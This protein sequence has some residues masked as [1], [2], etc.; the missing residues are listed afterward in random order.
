MSGLEAIKQGAIGAWKYKL[1]IGFTLLAIGL[2]GSSVANYYLGFF[3][4]GTGVPILIAF[5]LSGG[6]SSAAA[7]GFLL[8]QLHKSKDRTEEPRDDSYAPEEPEGAD[9]ALKEALAQAALGNKEEEWDADFNSEVP[10]DDENVAGACAKVQEL[11]DAMKNV[12]QMLGTPLPQD[13]D[14]EDGVGWMT[15]GAHG[16]EEE[17]LHEEPLT[18]Q[19]I[20]QEAQALKA[21]RGV[22]PPPP[23]PRPVS[24]EPPPLLSEIHRELEAGTRVL[25]SM[26]LPPPPPL[27]SG[28]PPKKL[29]P[30]PSE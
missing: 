5:S 8:K 15:I 29:P 16:A 12:D 7:V 13:N 18:P 21:Q 4:K 23:P 25:P 11:R 1:P 19:E 26:K 9:K 22:P 2:I 28:E 24:L 6:I 20:L 27:P 14:D 17:V 30:P 10:S 3:G